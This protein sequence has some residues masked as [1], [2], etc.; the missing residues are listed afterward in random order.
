M[1]RIVKLKGELVII[2]TI[3]IIIAF[4][5]GML[6]K[7]QG[8]GIYNKTPNYRINYIY[9]KTIID[10]EK[11]FKNMDLNQKDGVKELINK[12]YFFN[13][14]Y[15]FYIIDGTGKVY[16]GSND[17]VVAIDKQKAKASK[18]QYYVSK[19]ENTFK[20]V[21]CDY[22]KDGYYLYYSYLGDG[23]DDFNMMIYA[24]ICFVI[25]FFMLI[26]TRVSYISKIKVAV[27]SIAEGDLS[28]RAP[29]KFKNEL[30]E[31]AE[32]VNY[33][34]AELEN[35]DKKRGEF[36]TNISHDLRTPLTT[37]LGYID[38]LKKE[39]YDSK[40]ELDKYINIMERKGIFL[41]TM[42]EDF[43]QYSKLTSKDMVLNIEELE[44]N[45]FGR[46]LLEDEEKR[47]KNKS[48][49]LEVKLFKEPICIKGDSELLG[50]VV[51]NLL[52]NAFKYSK[53]HTIV[54]IMITKEKLNNI[55]YGV[56]S[57]CNTPKDLVSEEE[58]D[59]FFQRLYKKDQAR[60]EEGSGLGLSIVKD[61]IKL[62]GG[63]IKGY[64]EKGEL[65][66]NFKLKI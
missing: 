6:I 28:Q 53:K 62:H 55:N 65:I 12:K 42:L 36:L 16:T 15:S 59:N 58:V 24:L 17:E 40:A 64:K 31:L 66:F 8:V 22:L 49:T 52:N 57:V 41:R 63:V 2:S 39:K 26:W 7:A 51:N 11:D 60:H 34:S 21:G 25:I 10:A 29:L 35:E 38:M 46:Q 61:I 14:G 30:R 5:G 4:V 45:E 54:K 3:S 32:D 37:I 56:F 47:F 33:M 13:S 1:K 23:H 20:I 9:S 27:R 48:L 19:Q 43:F 50:R 18:P 44:L